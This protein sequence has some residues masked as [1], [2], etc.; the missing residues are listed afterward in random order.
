MVKK[1]LMYALL[2]ALLLSTRNLFVKMLG[3]NI[4]SGEIAFFRGLFGT[5]AV[6]IV[7]YT[8]G[9]RF[10]KEDR[11]Y[12]IMRGLY[13]G[14]GMVCNFIALVHLKASPACYNQPVSKNRLPFMHCTNN[15]DTIKH[16]HIQ[17]KKERKRL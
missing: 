16:F 3:S 14:F 12:L 7:M 15:S 9:I 6:L 2:S 4:P 8:Q 5:I 17:I 1:G 10:S 11:G 13:G